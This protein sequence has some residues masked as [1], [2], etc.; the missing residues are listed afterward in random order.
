MRE[1]KNVKTIKWK[2]SQLATGQMTAC[3]P[4]ESRKQREIHR[5]RHIEREREGGRERD[6]EKKT[7]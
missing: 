7:H 4:L 3:D 5:M 2:T 1:D 6:V